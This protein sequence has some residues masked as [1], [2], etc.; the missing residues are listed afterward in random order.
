MFFNIRGIIDFIPLI[1]YPRG[2]VCEE[3]GQ[4]LKPNIVIEN[5]IVEYCKAAVQLQL[6]TKFLTV[7]IFLMSR[8]LMMLLKQLNPSSSRANVV[9]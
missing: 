2:E 1:L 5:L 6:D 9:R 8:D 7:C 4:E 3:E